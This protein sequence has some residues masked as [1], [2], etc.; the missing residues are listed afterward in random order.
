M[1]SHNQPPLSLIR[2][3][4]ERRYVSGTTA[5]AVR[6]SPVVASNE[7]AA[8]NDMPNFPI[9]VGTKFHLA[10]GAI[11]VLQSPSLRDRTVCRLSSTG[12]KMFTA[13]DGLATA[14]RSVLA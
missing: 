7:P 12:L 3:F 2:M 11:V 13:Q 10:F 6:F 1:R 4:S 8:Y 14:A 5:K 9:P